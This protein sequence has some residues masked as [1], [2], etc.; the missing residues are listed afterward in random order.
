MRRIR[1]NIKKFQSEHKKVVNH[2]DKLFKTRLKQEEELGLLVKYNEEI[3]QNYKKINKI[4][5]S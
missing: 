4:K 3:L 1:E 2:R 5:F